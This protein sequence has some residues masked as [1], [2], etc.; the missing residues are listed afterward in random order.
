M[1]LKL[2]VL[3]TPQLIYNANKINKLSNHINLQQL[4]NDYI[5]ISENTK[6]KLDLAFVS[7]ADKVSSSGVHSLRLSDHS[8]IYIVHK[9][10]KVK[11]PPKFIKTRSFKNINE[12]EFIETIKQSNWN[13]ILDKPECRGCIQYFSRYV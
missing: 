7:K 6:S 8:M 4:I 12:H 2:R 10:K 11:V 9:N 5:R 1:F 3:F 13:Y